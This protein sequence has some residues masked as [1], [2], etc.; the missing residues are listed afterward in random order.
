M[1]R[2]SYRSR[3]RRAH[4]TSAYQ[5]KRRRQLRWGNTRDASGRLQRNPE[6]SVNLDDWATE[7]D[8]FLEQLERE[9]V[10]EAPPMASRPWL[11]NVPGGLLPA[12]IYAAYNTERRKGR[13]DQIRG[14]WHH[15]R[16]DL[17]PRADHDPEKVEQGRKNANNRA[18]GIRQREEYDRYE[19]EHPSKPPEGGGRRFHGGSEPPPEESGGTKDSGGIYSKHGRNYYHRKRSRKYRRRK[20]RNG[21][22]NRYRR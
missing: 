18:K 1:V 9:P 5:R 8:S 14:T 6:R 17:L 12:L 11:K 15:E 16:Q 21:R 4:K 19:R 3:H 2:R 10:R 13:R 22:Y 7:N 20:R